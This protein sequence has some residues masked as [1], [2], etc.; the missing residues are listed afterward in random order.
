MRR[1]CAMLQTQ[2][3]DEQELDVRRKFGVC[4][5]YGKEDEWRLGDHGRIEGEHIEVVAQMLAQAAMACSAPDAWEAFTV[6]AHP[7]EVPMRMRR[8]TNGRSDRQ[9]FG[10]YMAASSTDQRWITHPSSTNQSAP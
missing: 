10:L 8:R 2:C 6:L 9:A 4:L 3:R 5:D 1:C 7:A